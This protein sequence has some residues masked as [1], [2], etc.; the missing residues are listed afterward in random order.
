[1]IF[2]FESKIPNIDPAAF[3]SPT[4]SIIGDVE[5]GERT[6]VW[7]GAVIR[8]DFFPIRI[9]KYNSI[10][11]N[12]VIHADTIIGSYCRIAHGSVVHGCI[13]EDNILVGSNAT[14]FDGCKIG[15]GAII[16]IGA[17]V[18]PNTYVPSRT[19]MLGVPAKP[20]RKV[21]DEE[22]KD[23][24]RRA[25]RYAELAGRYLASGFNNI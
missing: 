15:E 23:M 11:D 25:M 24:I 21:S 17:V 16:G 2:S 4:A 5:I 12:V 13:L 1:M 10:Q 8:G 6:N 20:V 19:V 3:I 14:I 7:F 18:P 9:G 22:V